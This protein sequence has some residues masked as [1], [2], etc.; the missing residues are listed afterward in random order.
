MGS[1]MNDKNRSI[2]MP[3]KNKEKLEKKTTRENRKIIGSQKLLRNNNLL[4]G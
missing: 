4:N 3:R 2:T 1:R